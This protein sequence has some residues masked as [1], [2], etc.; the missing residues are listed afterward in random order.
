L[1]RYGP[2]FART[3]HRDALASFL[4]FLFSTFGFDF[5]S[6]YLCS[7]VVPFRFLQERSVEGAG[8]ELAGCFLFYFSF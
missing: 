2:P 5:I 4:R 8:Q 3:K 1:W 7:S 6:I